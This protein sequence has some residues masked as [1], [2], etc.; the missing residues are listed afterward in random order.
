MPT[1]ISTF[2]ASQKEFNAR[3][4]AAVDSIVKSFAGLSTDLETLNNKIL[5]LQNSPGGV[6]PEDQVLI[7][8]LQA[9]GSDLVARA[10]AVA[11]GLAKLD[12]SQPPVLPAP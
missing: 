6:T 12:N 11:E 3:Q 8:E 9:Q 5:E 10:E 2:I 4:G 1:P 7:D